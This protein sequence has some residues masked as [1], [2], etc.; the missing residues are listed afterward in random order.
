MESG[1]ETSGE[2]STPREE[3]EG[4][5]IDRRGVLEA[6]APFAR[7][8]AVLSVPLMNARVPVFAAAL[9][10]SVEDGPWLGDLVRGLA[11]AGVPVENYVVHPPTLAA[12]ERILGYEF[13]VVGRGEDGAPL[14]FIRGRYVAGHNDLQISLS[15]GRRIE[16]GRPLTREEIDGLVREGKVSL[17]VVY[18]Y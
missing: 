2:G 4:R 10:M 6:L 12:L 8:V 3:F 9:S 17:T 13:P 18:Y 11:S 15:I 1:S 7:R 14:R 16:E 5:E